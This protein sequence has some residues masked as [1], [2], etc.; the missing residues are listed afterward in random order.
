VAEP[1]DR[2]RIKEFASRVGV[3]EPTLRAW[4][5]R[6][7]L[8]QPERSSGGFRL[9]SPADEG[10]VRS[11]QAHMARGIGAAQAAGLA[12]AESTR[13]FVVPAPPDDLID[14]LIA[15]AE[16]FDVTRFD[17]L[18][19]AAF[20]HGRLP[21]IRDVVL[22]MLVE[23]GARWERGELSVG[24]EHL[25]SHL[26][27]RRLLGMARGWEGG[28][29]PLALLACPPGERHS[30]GLVCFGLLLAE[31]GWRIAYLGA[32]TPLDQIAAL[33]ASI[34]P[35]AVVLC[36][37]HPQSLLQDAGALAELGRRHHTV[38]GGRDVTAELA[39]QLGVHR[40]A[41]GP[42]AAA[43]ALAERPPRRRA[44]AAPK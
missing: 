35:M 42:V 2:W 31:Q 9:Y 33:S 37:L 25:T 41:G 3:Q 28:S 30:L 44:R 29:G 34:R 5:R 17:T 21:G 16:E 23:V 8:L 10:R 20:E 18:L 6:Y 1:G 7:R 24:D 43:Q 15:A 14:A 36:S 12:L 40:A 4:E 22:P 32:D 27:E 38:L 26:L 13:E 11:M 39:R 19:D